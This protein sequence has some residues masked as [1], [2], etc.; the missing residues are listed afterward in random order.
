M[1]LWHLRPAQVGDLDCLHAL[2]EQTGAG[3]TNLPS[4]KSALQ[5]RLDWNMRSFGREE[6]TPENELYILVLEEAGSGTVGG[7]GMIF[8]RIGVRWPF[9][10][11]KVSRL[12]QR[13]EEL[14]RTVPLDVLHL[15]ND[16]NGVSEVGG[17]FLS[18]DLRSLGLGGLLARSRYLFMG[19][20]RRRFAEKVIAELR[21]HIEPDGRSP[22]W[23]GL[24]RKFFGMSFQDADEFNSQHGNQFIADL[25]PKYP[26]YTAL[27]PQ[28][29]QAAIG[30][31]HDNG[32]PAMRMLEKE[33]FSFTGYVDIFDAGPTMVADTERLRTVQQMQVLPVAEIVETIPEDR[34]GFAAAG[35]LG[36]FRAWRTG[37]L[38]GE[39]GL[40]LTAEEASL[41]KINAGDTITYVAS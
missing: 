8:S 36:D 34:R 30:R 28:E 22:F 18:P 32:V 15:V 41:M 27:L 9:Y 2:A 5:A 33:G 26:V 13:S 16:F 20:N 19:M 21:G 6:E 11:Y 35:T 4:D 39:Q 38:V 17:L 37:A 24:G 23:D 29:A 3:F 1:T 10:S 25:M 31:P 12:S 7:C 14:G 40:T